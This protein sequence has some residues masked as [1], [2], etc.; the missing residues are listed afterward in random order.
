[1]NNSASVADLPLSTLPPRISILIPTLNAARTLEL[2]LA[3]IRNQDYPPDKTEIIIADAGSADDTRA[4]ATRH[5]VEKIVENPLKTGE[6]GKAAAA[7]AATGDIFVLIDSDNILPDANWLTRMTAPFAD[8]DVFASEPLEYTRR[9]SDHELT[10]YFAMLGMNDPLNLFIGNYDRYSAISRRW[11]EL[12][13]EATDCGDWL[14]VRIDTTQPL[15]TIGANGFLI[16]RNALEGVRWQPYWFDVD[17]V[18]EAAALSSNN[19]TY[20]AKVKTGIVHLYCDNLETFAR[21]QK[22][23]I[24]DFLYFSPERARATVPGERRQLL[25]GIATFTLATILVFPLI[26]QR[27]RANNRIADT[28]WR[29]H[30]P[31]CRIT[32]RTYA[33]GALRKLLGFKQAP[34]SRDNWRQ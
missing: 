22:R 31:V 5:K 33:A 2:C 13:M 16:R 21:K 4:I 1:M 25:I 15:P 19:A 8:P 7:Q 30:G 17:V 34:V 9:E 14:K 18:R 23:R 10:R 28:A 12:D 3:A 26:A 32:L 24:R 6:A 27:R 29:L 11:T 20:V